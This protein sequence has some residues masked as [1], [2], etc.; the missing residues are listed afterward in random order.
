[1]QATAP[2][3][4][5]ARDRILD[6][7]EQLVAAQGASSL[8]LDAVAQAAG[9][10]KGGL[11]YHYPN[12]DALLAAMIERHCD[13]LDERC[14]RELEDLPAD[15]PSSR[16]KAS[17]LGV[18]T[19]RAGREDLGA[20]LLAAAANKPALLDGARARYADH[21][22]QLTASGGCFA[23]SAVIMLAVDGLMLGEVWRLTPFTSEQRDLIVKEL[24]RLADEACP[25]LS[26]R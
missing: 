13:D 26:P 24:L 21:V 14:A 12:K 1:M 23:R 3:L 11:L 9:V 6:A 15:Q 4:P 2:V 17:I 25:E 10:S 19:P 8:T 7:A 20:A 18:L 16:L 5:A 22:A